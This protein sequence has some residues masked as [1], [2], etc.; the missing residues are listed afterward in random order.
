MLLFGA[1][2][3]CSASWN[4]HPGEDFHALGG[5]SVLLAENKCS[6]QFKSTIDDYRRRVI[7]LNTTIDW[8]ICIGWLA[9]PLSRCLPVLTSVGIRSYLKKFFD[10]IRVLGP[11]LESSTCRHMPAVRKPAPT[12]ILGQNLFFETASRRR[13]SWEWLPVW[14]F[15]E[16]CWCRPGRRHSLGKKKYYKIDELQQ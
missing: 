7:S 1:V 10:P 15:L 4:A 8:I 9:G 12:Y 16:C 11:G 14:S 3:A 5:A 2:I 13:R 6:T